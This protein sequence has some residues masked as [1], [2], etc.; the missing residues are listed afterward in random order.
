MGIIEQSQ[1]KIGTRD[2]RETTVRSVFL[3]FTKDQEWKDVGSRDLAANVRLTFL[4]RRA[5]EEPR[6]QWFRCDTSQR[7]VVG[8]AFYHSVRVQLVKTRCNMLALAQKS[9]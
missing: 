7:K 5:I 8:S 3:I 1:K 2:S 4:F 9:W 6:S